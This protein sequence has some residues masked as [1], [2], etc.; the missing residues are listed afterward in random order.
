MRRGFGVGAVERRTQTQKSFKVIGDKVSANEI[1]TLKAQFATFHNSLQAFAHKHR[2]EIKSDPQFRM[3]FQRMCANIGVDPLASTKGIWSELLGVGDFY[4]ELAVQ[5][6]DV[7][8]AARAQNGGLMALQEVIRRVT[9]VRTRAAKAITAATGVKETPQAVTE[10]DVLRAVK[11]LKPLGNGFSI[12]TLAIDSAA[13]T[14]G[15][16][17][18]K[19]VRSVPTELDPD[20]SALLALAESTPQ[21]AIT[22]TYVMK[23]L[24]WSPERTHQALSELVLQGLCWV[25]LQ[26]MPQ[27]G[28]EEYWVT[29]FFNEGRGL[30]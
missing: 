15:I 14:S 17:G 25:D 28:Q 2:K 30:S 18:R 5:I 3:H 6:I 20:V 7:C 27:T 21:G 11:T 22:R 23:R 16:V 26:A 29:S 19:M 12:I 24:A 1:E 4:Y 10:D 9:L 13:G 8:L